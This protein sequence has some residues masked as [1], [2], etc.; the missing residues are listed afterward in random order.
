MHR[1]S[2]SQGNH[3]HP[4][5][6]NHGRAFVIAI[7][8]NITFVVVEFTYGFI[9][10]STALMADAGHNLSDV[11]GLALA[12]GA[13][14]LARKAANERYTYGLRSSSILAALANAMLL[15]IACGAIAWEAVQRF[16][17]PP[18][19]A[20]LTVTLVAV[21]G[22]IINGFSAWLFMKGS[23]GD[24]N[25]RGAYLHMAADAAVSAGVVIAGIAMIFTG[26]YWLDPAVSLLIVGVVIMSTWGLLRDSVQ[27]ALSA[28]P[29]HIEM[30]AIDAYLRDQPGVTDI[31]DLHIWGLSTT[32]SALTV[33]LVMPCG[34]PGDA[35]MDDIRETLNTRFSVHHSTIQIEQ[36]ATRHACSLEDT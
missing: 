17:Q 9:A 34:Y 23:K 31:H 3:Q 15:L 11:L 28:V 22:V 24:L 33:H 25:I 6:D 10:N 13:S 32:E 30:S 4:G 7:V 18:V 14:I 29:P 19:V 27:L 2:H 21:I 1:S 36:G 16:L 5:S 26:W 20:G 12:A 35:F 8:L